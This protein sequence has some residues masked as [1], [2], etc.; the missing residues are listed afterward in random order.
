MICR[1]G[2]GVKKRGGGLKVLKDNHGRVITYMRLS[3]TD[4]CN[5]RCTYCVP[6]EGFKALDHA[7]ILTYEEILRV[8]RL[9][10]GLG[11]NKFRITGGEPLVRRGVIDLVGNISAIDGVETTFTTNGLLLDEMAAELKEAGVRR[12]NISLDSLKADRLREI[13]RIDCFEKVMKGIDRACEIGFDPI[14]LNVVLMKGVNDDEIEDFVALTKERP[15]HVRFIEFMPMM[16]N[17]WD[18]KRFI[19][20]KKIEEMLSGLFSLERDPD[21]KASSPSRNYIV[22]GH[23]G[24]IGVISPVSR[25]FCDSC[26]RIRLTSDGHIKSCLLR[27]EE[28]DLKGPMR[29]GAGD[30]EIRALI[31]RAV[32]LKPLGHLLKEDDPETIDAFRPMTQ[33]GG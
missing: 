3:V 8:V 13:T 9:S 30:D 7:D 18:K 32:M 12:L 1:T 11:V 10:N 5:M 23:M 17:G 22:K 24:K 14:K 16:E 28:V 2:S 4:R 26:N 15:Y 31:E 33:I 27:E 25:H 21:E 6:T 29:E 20:A 19:P